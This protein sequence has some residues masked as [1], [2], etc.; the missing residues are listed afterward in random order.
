MLQGGEIREVTETILLKLKTFRILGGRGQYMAVLGGL[1]GAIV[2]VSV[3]TGGQ[4]RVVPV[5]T[6]WYWITIGHLGIYAFV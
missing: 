3:G 6:W 1:F 2:L 5:G 4:Y